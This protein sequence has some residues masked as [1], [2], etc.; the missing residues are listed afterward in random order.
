VINSSYI[1]LRECAST[2]LNFFGCKDMTLAVEHVELNS[3]T[4]TALN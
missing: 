1:G 2:K 4:S 3:S